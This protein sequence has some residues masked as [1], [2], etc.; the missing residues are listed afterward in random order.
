M[1]SPRPTMGRIGIMPAGSVIEQQLIGGDVLE[2]LDV[3]GGP[4]D[5]DEVGL[6]GVAEAEVGDE[7]GAGLGITVAGQ[8]ADLPDFLAADG[9]L[10]ADLGADAGAVGGLALELDLEPVVGAFGGGEV[11]AVEMVQ[12]EVIATAN[13]EQ[14]QP[15]VVVVVHETHFHPVISIADGAADIDLLERAVA[16]V[17][18]EH[19]WITSWRCSESAIR[20]EDVQ[21]AIV[22]VVP[23]SRGPSCHGHRDAGLNGDVGE[24]LAWQTAVEGVRPRGRQSR[25]AHEQLRRPVVV[26]VGPHTLAAR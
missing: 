25:S 16:K 20:R 4:F 3:A 23:N 2:F 6:G 9:G 21:P 24:V 22:V 19:I 14:V 7:A 15:A 8:F 5:A 12:T 10:D 17:V 1:E 13:H 26:E 18:E 11:V